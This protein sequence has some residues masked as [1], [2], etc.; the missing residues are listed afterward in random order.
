MGRDLLL[1]TDLPDVRPRPLDFGAATTRTLEYHLAVL[2]YIDDL[3]VERS[4]TSPSWYV[5]PW[6]GRPR[7]GRR[8]RKLSGGWFSAA[9]GRESFGAL[10]SILEGQG[11]AWRGCLERCGWASNGGEEERQLLTA[12]VRAFLESLAGAVEA[13]S[14]FYLTI[15]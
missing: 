13:G 11:D 4:F 5:K 6:H 10:L 12:D 14:K 1:I 8:P 9:D 2:G 3:A 7:R 15:M